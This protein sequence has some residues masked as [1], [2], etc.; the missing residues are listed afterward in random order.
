[1]DYEVL[2]FGAEQNPVVVIDD[3]HPDPDELRRAAI[4]LDYADR[5]TGFPGL[6]APFDPNYM[7]PAMPGLQAVLT[8]VFGL[9]KG[10]I[11][12]ECCA[13]IVTVPP[14][15]LR[16]AQCMPHFDGADPKLM[17]LL[18]YIDHPE[19][20]GTGFYRHKATGFES[21][22]PEREADYR[23]AIQTQREAGSLPSG[24]Y[25]TQSGDLVE[26]IG[27]VEGRYNRMVLYR[28]NI[29]H[30]GDINPENE[31]CDD[32][33]KARLSINTFLLGR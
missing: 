29:L 25:M 20:G 8:D 11:L 12:R 31:F 22:T 28:S 23:A 27:S 15:D 6:R 2:R 17:A 5:S 4:G 3:F 26:K 7:G 24:R 33:A 21:V 13:S 14:A 16:P 30:S 1:M 10:V 19:K 9:S 32:P 18:H